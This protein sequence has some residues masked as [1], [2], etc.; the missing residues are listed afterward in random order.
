MN[1]LVL[2]HSPPDRP[3]NCIEAGTA[4]WRD[5]MKRGQ[6]SRNF[7]LMLVLMILVLLIVILI[8]SFHF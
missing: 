3:H 5:A 6:E 1:L 7:E 8:R 4:S 2:W